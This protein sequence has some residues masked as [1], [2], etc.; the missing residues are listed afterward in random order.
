MLA[1]RPSGMGRE[2][3]S[4]EGKDGLRLRTP[5][6]WSERPSYEI[7]CCLCG[8]QAEAWSCCFAARDGARARRIRRICL[9]VARSWSEDEQTACENEESALFVPN[10]ITD[11]SAPVRE[12]RYS[13]RFAKLQL[14]GLNPACPVCLTVALS[15]HPVEQLHHSRI[16]SSDT[17]LRQLIVVSQN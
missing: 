7:R 5:A 1:S 2:K 9:Q 15:R 14:G 17:V 16:I 13:T 8:C 4:I 3:G 12:I 11:E 10:R 6:T